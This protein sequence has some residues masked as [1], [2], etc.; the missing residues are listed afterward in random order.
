MLN[1]SC[2]LHDGRFFDEMLNSVRDFQK[3][4]RKGYDKT[5]SPTPWS[6]L[7]STPKNHFLLKLNVLRQFRCTYPH[8]LLY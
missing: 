3:T 1:H 7:W 5:R 8:R 2:S 6:T 4:L